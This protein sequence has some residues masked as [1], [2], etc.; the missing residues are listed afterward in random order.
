MIVY[1]VLIF[2][3]L[4]L[5]DRL[6][7]RLNHHF[8]QTVQDLVFEPLYRAFVM[9]CFIFLSYPVLFGITDTVGIFTLLA[10]GEQ[11]TSHLVNLVFITSLL[12]PLIPG[13]GKLIELVLPVQAIL[14]CMMVFSWLAQHNGLQEYSY[15][16]GIPVILLIVLL[17]LITHW[18]SVTLA[19]HAGTWLDEAWNVTGFEELLGES[20]IL[21]MQAPAILVYSL[22]LGRQL[23]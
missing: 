16:P 8:L 10:A 13:P 23:A 19:R 22:T 5:L 12:L 18:L 17:A 7:H 20:I 6:H 11:R 15:W 9:V 3:G 2:A 4:L 1:A 21:F 14:C